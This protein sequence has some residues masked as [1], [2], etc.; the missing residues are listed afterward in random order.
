MTFMMIDTLVTD[1]KA[2]KKKM[3]MTLVSKRDYLR[4]VEG[5]EGEGLEIEMIEGIVVIEVEI[6]TKITKREEE[7][8]M[9]ETKTTAG[10][11]DFEIEM[12]ADKGGLLKDRVFRGMKR[13]SLDRICGEET[14]KM[15]SKTSEGKMI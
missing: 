1:L 5:L 4:K 12:K 2:Y 3:Q 10:G 7:V 13:T 6:I 8:G 15:K 11:E 9:I 14:L